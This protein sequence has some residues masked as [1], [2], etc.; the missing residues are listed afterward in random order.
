MDQSQYSA[1]ENKV[2]GALRSSI[3]NSSRIAQS[4]LLKL[5]KS[6]D[7]AKEKERNFRELESRYHRVKKILEE[8]EIPQTLRPLPFNSG[9]FMSFS[10][11]GIS[12]EELRKHLLEKGIGTIS[13]GEDYLRIAYSNI[14]VS[15]LEELYRE[16]FS[17]AAA[18]SSL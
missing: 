15:A 5:I 6:K 4:L 11:H 12:A 7:Y 18:L 13:I 2:M 9:Y 1:L 8:T 16:V 3:S 14:E 17:S 10:C